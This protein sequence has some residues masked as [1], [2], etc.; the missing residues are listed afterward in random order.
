MARSWLLCFDVDGW[1]HTLS[2][3]HTSSHTS[4]VLAIVIIL[5]APLSSVGMPRE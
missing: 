2:P 3:P 5:S 4:L 1:H